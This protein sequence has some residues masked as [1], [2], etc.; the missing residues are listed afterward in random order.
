MNVDEFKT[1]N[2]EIGPFSLHKGGKT[3]TMEYGIYYDSEMKLPFS[4]RKRHVRVWLPPEY[5][6]HPDWR[7]PVLYMSDGQNLVDAELSAFGDWHLDRCLHHLVKEQGVVPPILVGIDCP[8]NPATRA[9]ELCPPYLVRSYYRKRGLPTVPYANRFVN[10]IADVLKPLIDSLFRTDSRR[11]STA[12]G[13][14]SMGGIM[15]FY[16]YF[17]RKDIFGFSLAFSIPF[18]FY[19]KLKWSEILAELGAIPEKCGKMA[20]FVGGDGYERSFVKGNLEE[21]AYLR[22]LGFGEDQ[23]I[24]MRDSSRPHH[25]EAW[26]DYSFPALSFWLNALK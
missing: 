4:R 12:I 19:D 17:Y 13:G 8:K 26:A 22:H 5:A 9:L 24:F 3:S 20:M 23:I 16:S 21:I 2:Q 1:A 18:F 6:A 11:E 14:S 15:A 7:F 10:Y 25:E